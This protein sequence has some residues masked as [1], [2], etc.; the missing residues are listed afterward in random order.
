[1][2]KKCPLLRKPCI[3][4]DCAWWQHV[5]GEHPQTGAM[6]DHYNCALLWTN[7]LLI[8]NTKSQAGTAAA[9]ESFRNEMVDANDRILQLQHRGNGR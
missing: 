8:E 3:E 4:H 6:L 5:L 1:M 2:A 9:V 7:L